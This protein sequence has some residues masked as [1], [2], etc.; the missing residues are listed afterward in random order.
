VVAEA[1]QIVNVD[2]ATEDLQRRLTE[3]K[4]Y[5]PERAAQAL[6][7]F[8][9]RGNLEQLR[10]L[11]LRETASVIEQRGRL[12]AGTP[13]DLG[14]QAPDQ[15]AVCLASRGP[16]AEAL[17]RYASRLAGRLNR[18]WYALHV[19][20]PEEAPA[21]LDEATRKALAETL[22]LARRLGAMVFTF[23]GEDVVDTI[24]RFA[25]EYRVGN[26]V[27]GRP[28]P[29]M[30]RTPAWRRLARSLGRPP[31]GVRLD[32]LVERAAGLAVIVVDPRANPP[33]TAE[34]RRP[35][36]DLAEP[37]EAETETATAA[38][39][40]RPGGGVPHLTDLLSPQ[41]V[42]FFPRP[43]EKDTLLA[44]LVEA[45]AGS[46]PAVDIERVLGG[47]ALRE[48]DAS[49]FLAEGIAL[50]HVR[51][52][53]LDEP[54]IALGVPRAGVLDARGAARPIAVV[55]LFLVP[56][57]RP[58]VGLALLASAARLFRDGRFR[59]GLA[60]A[61]TGRDVVALVAQGEASRPI[62]IKRP[63]IERPG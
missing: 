7:S 16:D 14:V 33:V 55:F 25:R 57:S 27:I 19:E 15:V 42:V 29:G 10:E 44:R 34:E 8:F 4:V 2:L 62:A 32:E 13:E 35:A 37:D 53:G 45:A 63:A 23:K 54:R 51:V 38:I 41:G 59:E 20:T 46:P 24:L 9:R 30:V 17:L 11:A 26:L 50:P 56:E 21:R 5:A 49:T 18:T 22:D 3:G 60:S 1:D 52:V 58:E 40:P 12:A 36:A 28:R 31:A 6:K 39:P 47:L 61:A 48:R 43:V